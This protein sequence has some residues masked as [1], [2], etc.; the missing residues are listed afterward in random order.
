M[1]SVDVDAVLPLP[2]ASVATPA[3]SDTITVLPAAAAAVT[4]DT[5]TLYVVPLP[6][7]VTVAPPK[8]AVPV[9]ATSL[10]M[11]P[12]TAS[13]KTTVKSIGSVLVGSACVEGAVFWLMVTVGTV[14]S[15]V[16]VLSVD[17]DAALSLPA[18][19]WA[20]AASTAAMTLPV[21]VMPLTETV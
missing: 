18:A 12:L 7:T 10:P 6:V 19:S 4:P 17:V 5:A 14:V 20:A 2:A 15:Y 11:K 13:E 1:L 9:S 8:P 16:T 3:G 21:P